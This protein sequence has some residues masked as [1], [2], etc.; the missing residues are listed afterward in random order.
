MRIPKARPLVVPMPKE[1]NYKIEEGRY[2]ARIHKIVRTQRQNGSGC[3]DILR[4]VF[5]LQVPGKEN[6]INL[7]KAEFPLNLEHGSELR[8]VLARLLGKDVLAAK[9][10]GEM[11]FEILLGKEADVEIEHIITNKSDQYDY[12]FVHVCEIQ[13]PGTLVQVKPVEPQPK[14]TNQ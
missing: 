3:A 2:R 6:F 10:G 4:I 7:A 13:P 8:N 14:E 5:E 1:H 11:D 9:S 12:P